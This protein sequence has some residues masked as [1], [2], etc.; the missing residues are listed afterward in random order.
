MGRMTTA[1]VLATAT[2]CLLAQQPAAKKG[3][4]DNQAG[5][6]AEYLKT[7]LNVPQWEQRFEKEGREVF[8][9]RE[10]IL[11][12]CQVKPGMAVGDIGAGTGLFT[13]LFSRQV[14][15]GGKVYAVDIAKDF[16]IRIEKKAAEAGL[17]NIETVLCT[18][19][20]TRLPPESIDLAFLCDTYHHFEHPADTLVS[21]YQALRPGGILVVVD[22]RR[23]PGKSTE[24]ILNHVRCGEEQ[25]VREIEATG[26][27]K[28]E[29]VDFMKENY[30]L[31]FEK[32]RR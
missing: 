20:S 27:K 2:V 31:R 25:V 12:H 22:Y 24:W 11:E 29:T 30:L 21:I 7:N 10:K 28:L 16:L 26:F 3:Q 23:E 1:L 13:L 5:V 19:K 18:D 8:D 6:N 9:F 14:A 15:P 17:K 4:P 32:Q